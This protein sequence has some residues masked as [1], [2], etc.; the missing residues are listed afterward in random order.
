MERLLPDQLKHATTGHRLLD[1]TG[2]ASPQAAAR[3]CTIDVE[4]A[5]Q[6]ARSSRA[7]WRGP[8]PVR[9]RTGLLQADCGSAEW[10]SPGPLRLDSEADHGLAAQ[11]ATAK[12]VQY[13]RGGG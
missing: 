3:R 5:R 11:A 13:L 9:R 8:G 12:V 10:S 7:S 2:G 1:A 4:R 6:K